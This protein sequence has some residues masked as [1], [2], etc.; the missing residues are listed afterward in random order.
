[1]NWLILIFFFLLTILLILVYFLVKKS[2][3]LCDETK[4]KNCAYIIEKYLDKTIKTPNLNLSLGDF[5]YYP[6]A[7]SPKCDKLWYSVRYV[8][9]AD[10]GYSELSNWIGPI[11]AGSCSLPCYDPNNNKALPSYKNCL[12]DKIGQGKNSLN[13]NEVIIASQLP[14]D[15]GIQDGIFINLHR[16]QGE[17]PPSDNDGEIIGLMLPTNKFNW[18]GMGID[19]IPVNSNKQC[20][21]DC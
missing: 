11:Y 13:F 7:G 17:N 21:T 3:L 4:W 1:M 16:Y 20:R 12:N 2:F 10:G 14:F 15:Y 6:D 5:K 18:T 8:K 19:I 9:E